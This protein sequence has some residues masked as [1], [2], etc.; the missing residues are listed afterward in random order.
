VHLN[1]RCRSLAPVRCGVP[2]LG[3]TLISAPPAGHAMGANVRR[4]RA[5]ARRSCSCDGSLRGT[6]RFRQPYR[7]RCPC[8][9][10][11]RAAECTAQ[12]Y[13]AANTA[14]G[15]LAGWANQP[16]QSLSP[17]ERDAFARSIL[18]RIVFGCKSSPPRRATDIVDLCVACS[19]FTRPPN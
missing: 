13:M 14:G 15:V 4:G 6:E 11:R 18:S 9:Q 12:L 8:S 7:G 17:G 16:H 5:P 2:G 1:L 10:R 3:L 19:T